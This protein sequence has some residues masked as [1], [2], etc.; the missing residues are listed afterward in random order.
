MQQLGPV[1][2]IMNSANKGEKALP[3]IVYGGAGD[4]DGG[5]GSVPALDDSNMGNDATDE[6]S[7]CG[8]DEDTGVG[9]EQPSW[10][11]QPWR[12]GRCFL[13]KDLNKPSTLGG[14]I[15]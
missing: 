15:T 2:D 3:G 7:E 5:L 11:I 10:W 14:T 12:D 8:D 6:N 9:G 1:V 13:S 4:A